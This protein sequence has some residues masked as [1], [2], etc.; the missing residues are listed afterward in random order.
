MNDSQN[1][2]K[3]YSKEVADIISKFECNE[4]DYIRF[5]EALTEITKTSKSEKSEITDLLQSIITASKC[6]FDKCTAYIKPIYGTCY[7]TNSGTL[8]GVGTRDFGGW[9]ISFFKEYN[10]ELIIGKAYP[11]FYCYNDPKVSQQVLDDYA[12][13]KGWEIYK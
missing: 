2:I 5:I 4:L 3:A 7:R 6:I 1:S 9:T 8:V 12:I 10:N 11:K 13:A